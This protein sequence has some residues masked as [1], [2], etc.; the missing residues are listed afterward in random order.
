M[1]K[2]EYAKIHIRDDGEIFFINAHNQFN[3]RNWR[4]LMCAL[5][6]LGQ[7]GWLLCSEVSA[8]E[9]DE[10]HYVMSREIEK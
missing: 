10:K 3:T 7:Y 8:C 1:K 9:E 6:E 2:Y 5:E 4:S